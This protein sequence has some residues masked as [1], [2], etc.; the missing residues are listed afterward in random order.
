MW[1]AVCMHVCA[2]HVVGCVH[3]CVGMHVLGC[4][5]GYVHACM[6]LGCGHVCHLCTCLDMV[7]VLCACMLS[8]NQHG[9]VEICQH[10]HL[11]PRVCVYVCV[12]DACVRVCVCVHVPGR[13]LC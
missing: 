4:V 13:A 12:R 5:H 9:H 7:L 6:V 3:A 11:F 1:F 2:M 10:P 8:M